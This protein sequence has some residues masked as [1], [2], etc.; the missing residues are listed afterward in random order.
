M[1]IADIKNSKS[2]IG[3][4][5][6]RIPHPFP[7]M[8]CSHKGLSCDE[9]WAQKS[10]EFDRKTGKEKTDFGLMDFTILCQ[11]NSQ[12]Y[13]R[14]VSNPRSDAPKACNDNTWRFQHI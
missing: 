10:L 6:S 7:I 14:D 1:K 3:G 9:E 11:K 5:P 2:K 4:V 8:G 13:H 12:N